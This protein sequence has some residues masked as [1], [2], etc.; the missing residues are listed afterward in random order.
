ML[1][2]GA[3][4]V[5]AVTVCAM[6]CAAQD[7]WFLSPVSF[8]V[9]PGEHLEV[10][11]MR[12]RLEER[13]EDAAAVPP[14]AAAFPTELADW[15]F[16][17]GGGEQWNLHHPDPIEA[18]PARIELPMPTVGVAMIGMDCAPTVET[19][20]PARL[21]A[22]IAE[23]AP[24]FTDLRI[25]EAAGGVRVRVNRSA[26]ALVRLADGRTEG[27]AS[28]VATSKAGQRSEIRLNVDP[29]VSAVGSEVPVRLYANWKSRMGVTFT[30]THV[31]SGESRTIDVNE[32][33]NGSVVLDAPGVWRLE[34]H[35]FEPADDDEADF[36]LYSAT[37]TF[38]VPEE[39]ER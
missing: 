11:V 5:T 29:T 33:G 28:P 37:L 8:G 19:V 38:D 23:R 39:V 22:F 16:V 9:K 17:R 32:Y 3:L 13:V 2:R 21:R 7:V 12:E 34:F 25:P 27:M 31:G 20:S 15:V 30:A 6:S 1:T 18:A 36:D 14:D 26:K 10:A 35:Y 24:R 4:A